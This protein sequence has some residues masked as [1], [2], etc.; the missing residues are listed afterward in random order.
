[1]SFQIM[2]N[3]TNVYA[4][5]QVNIRRVPNTTGFIKFMTIKQFEMIDKAID[6]DVYSPSMRLC[7]KVLSR[8]GLRV[9]DCC[10]LKRS[11]FNADFSV[12]TKIMAKTKETVVI[13]LPGELSEEIKKFWYKFKN[14]RMRDNYLFFA[15]YSNDSKNAHLQ[16]S[17]VGLKLRDLCDKLK[18]NQT[19]HRRADGKE[20]RIISCHTLRHFFIWRVAE[21]S[22]LPMAQQL[23]G[24]KNINQ[25]AKYLNA[26]AV[27]NDPK[28]VLEKAYDF[29]EAKDERNTSST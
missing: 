14:T 27:A 20:L 15:N 8:T 3:A 5:T 9:G 17:S 24:H 2:E 23:V 26:L 6:K 19:Y 28:K 25:T 10:S 12:L 7:L 1:M 4:E 13:P 18:L 29:K 16:K 21:T 22:G 11:D